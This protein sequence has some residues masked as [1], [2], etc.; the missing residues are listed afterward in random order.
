MVDV[1][2]AVVQIRGC[3]VLSRLSQVIASGNPRLE[4]VYL[5]Y[6]I[7]CLHARMRLCPHNAW[8]SMLKACELVFLRQLAAWLSQGLLHDRHGEFF[9]KRSSQVGLAWVGCHMFGLR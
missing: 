7:A 1:F 6:S 4:A 5:Q 8:C 3:A 9:I 2:N